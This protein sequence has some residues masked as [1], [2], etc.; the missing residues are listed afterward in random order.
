[1]FTRN[2]FGSDFKFVLFL[3]TY[4][5]TAASFRSLTWFFFNPSFDCYIMTAFTLSCCEVNSV[6]IVQ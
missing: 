3:L 2:N 5:V 4:C 6:A 1:M